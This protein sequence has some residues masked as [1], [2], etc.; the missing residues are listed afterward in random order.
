MESGCG[1]WIELF[2]PLPGVM[3][4]STE[5]ELRL[6]VLLANQPLAIRIHESRMVLYGLLQNGEASVTLNPVGRDDRYLKSVRAFLSERVLGSPGGYPLYLQRWTRMGRMR[7]ESLE[8]LL[9]LGD[10]TAVFAVVCASGL[11][12]EIARRAW[13]ASEDAENA[14]RMLQTEQVVKGETGK[15][16]ARYLVDYLPFESEAETMIESVRMAL[17][18]GLLA[19]SVRLDLW[20]KSQ[21][22]APYLVGF[23]SACPDNLPLASASAW[24]ADSTLLVDLGQLSAAGNGTAAL[25]RKIAS[26][27]GQAFI[28]TCSRILR[29]PT[30][31]EVVTGTMDALRNYCAALRLEGDPDLDFD[32][33]LAEAEDYA[34]SERQSMEILGMAPELRPKIVALRVLSGLGYGVLRPLLKGSDAIGSL[35]RRK[36]EPV[37][38]PL[39]VL[40]DCLLSP[41]TA[42]RSENTGS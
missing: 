16:L 24:G 30:T 27:E 28:D 39:L 35:M 2:H 17:Q 32:R 25:L 36:L 38:A 10:P 3:Q 6:S 1:F 19:E 23:V 40:L 14:R 31:Q 5:D 18:P 4:L 29:K 41:P 21:R 15:K 26:S 9:L 11:T 42:V 34:G 13:W 8:Q 20:R 12:D 22:K 33:L 37:S 7:E